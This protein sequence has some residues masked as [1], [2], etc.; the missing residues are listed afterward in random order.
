M[1]G[2]LLKKRYVVLPSRRVLVVRTHCYPVGFDIAAIIRNDFYF[3]FCV[4]VNFN[5]SP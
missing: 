5:H 1:V 2:Y 3:V 4:P